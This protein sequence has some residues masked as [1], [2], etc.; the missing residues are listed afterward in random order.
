MDLSLTRR[1]S[2][3][4]MTAMLSTP[5]I[6]QESRMLFPEIDARIAPPSYAAGDAVEVRRSDGAWQLAEVRR[7]QGEYYHV[8]WNA[9]E[10]DMMKKQVHLSVAG[11]L[12]RPA[13]EQLGR[14]L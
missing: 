1:A 12:L 8:V 3:R 7:L 11:M 6:D 5:S 10:G 2:E 9:A 14:L 13:Q 4:T